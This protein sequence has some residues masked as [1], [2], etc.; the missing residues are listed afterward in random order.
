MIA[1]MATSTSLKPDATPSAD[2]RTAR[3]ERTRAAIAEAMLALIQD[4]VLRPTAPVIAE[5]AGVS[6]R[7][8]FQHFDDL[9]ALYAEVAD[10]QIGR[11]LATAR[12]VPREGPLDERIAAFVGERARMH[13]AVSPVRRSAL[14]VEPFSTEVASRLRMTREQGRIEVGKVFHIE[15][16]QHA[17]AE[18]RELLEAVTAA[19]SWSAWET[20]RVHQGL[21]QAQ[22]R[23]VLQRMVTSILRAN[24]VGEGK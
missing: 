21:S 14:L 20:L 12:L 10:L 19:A 1:S 22:A 8:V 13:E 16:E 23:K 11:V 6:L 15:L 24:E 3:A 9:E 5:T 7:S 18:R 2:G 17:A 4:G